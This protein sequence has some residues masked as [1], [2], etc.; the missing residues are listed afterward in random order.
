MYFY[1]D[2]KSKFPTK[3]QFTNLNEITFTLITYF[4]QTIP[5]IDHVYSILLH[6]IRIKQVYARFEALLIDVKSTDPF[7]SHSL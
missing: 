2:R 3:M 4:T 6:N 1:L 5:K 7:Q